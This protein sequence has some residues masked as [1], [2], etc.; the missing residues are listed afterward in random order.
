MPRSETRSSIRRSRLIGAGCPASPTTGHDRGARASPRPHHTSPS[1][2]RLGTPQDPHTN[3]R[4]VTARNAYGSSARRSIRGNW[5]VVLRVFP[6]EPSGCSLSD[7]CAGSRLLS[8]V[9]SGVA[10]TA[11][12]RRDADGRRHNSGQA[13]PSGVPVG[14]ILDAGTFRRPRR[15]G[16][17]WPRGPRPSRASPVLTTPQVPPK[18]HKRGLKTFSSHCS[19]REW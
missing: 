9:L 19:P 14:L 7:K 18:R 17:S 6:T 13:P 8:Q 16:G 1:P 4:R 10:A 2:H 3:S 5:V 12:D 11:F 15:C